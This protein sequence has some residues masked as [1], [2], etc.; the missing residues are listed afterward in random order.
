MSGKS[1]ITINGRAYDAI[2]GMPVASAKPAPATHKPHQSVPKSHK[3][4][5]TPPHTSVDNV[6]TGHPN[7]HIVHKQLQKSQTLY[8]AALR[9][10]A[11]IRQ[12]TPSPVT[13]EVDSPPDEKPVDYSHSPAISRFHNAPKHSSVA[14]SPQPSQQQPP[15]LDTPPRQHPVVARA[16]QNRPVNT[17][18]DAA[19][20][21]KELK[22]ALIRERLAEAEPNTEAPTKRRRFTQPRLATILTSSLALLLLAGYLT[23]LNLPNISMRVA[24]TRAGI[25][26][27]YPNYHPDGYHFSG[28]ITYQPGEVTINFKSNTN[29]QGFNVQQKSSNWD[30]Q[31]VLDNL[32][33][34]QSDTYLTYQERGLTIYSYGNHAAWVNGGLLYT[35]DGNAPLSSEQVLHV[36]TS[37]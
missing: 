19:Q 32:V 14:P 11:P 24:A 37:M 35:I 22:E 21:S 33:S 7:A 10:P 6:A 5:I 23:Y 16:L 2:S 15:R 29:D 26:A 31:A 20:T 25:A 27:N 30:S 3:S 18:T 13:V 28:P 1:I 8:R 34:K 4:N 17:P 36:A 12:L 9:K